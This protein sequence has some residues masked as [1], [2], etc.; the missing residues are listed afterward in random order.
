MNLH[1][2]RGKRNG[3]GSNAKYIPNTATKYPVD[4]NA[5]PSVR[6]CDA[7]AFTNTFLPSSIDPV[8]TGY[9]VINAES[10][11]YAMCKR[12]HRNPTEALPLISNTYG[13]K[14]LYRLPNLVKL[15]RLPLSIK[16]KRVRK[17]AAEEGKEDTVSLK[18]N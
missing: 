6:W 1:I 14:R 3:I 8:T 17:D 7:R 5:M 9:K 16:V 18:K 13:N 4:K 10:E 11:E 2:H 12:P 15:A